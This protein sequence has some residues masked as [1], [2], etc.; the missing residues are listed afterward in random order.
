[1]VTSDTLIGALV[2]AII[3][4]VAGGVFGLIGVYIGYRFSLRAEMRARRRDAYQ[5]L[6]FF[7]RCLR[8]TTDVADN[9][10]EFEFRKV[11]AEFYKSIYSNMFYYN[12]VQDIRDHLEYFE[13]IY[14]SEINPA[15]YETLMSSRGKLGS[16]IKELY[17]FMQK[18][19]NQFCRVCCA[20]HSQGRQKV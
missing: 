14:H 4:A 12:E 6:Y 2:G 3:G 9:Q 19:I 11:M 13:D 20:H 5:K 7:A 10:F 1:M 17:Q 16:A 8:N 18:R 15:L